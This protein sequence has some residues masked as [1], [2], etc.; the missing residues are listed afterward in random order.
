MLFICT[1]CLCWVEL[2]IS[3]CIIMVLDG[4]IKSQAVSLSLCRNLLNHRRL[5]SSFSGDLEHSFPFLWFA[6]W[7]SIH[8]A[9]LARASYNFPFL[10]VLR[11]WR[12]LFNSK[13][14]IQL[15]KREWLLFL[16]YLP[17]LCKNMHFFHFW[18][19][20]KFSSS[21]LHGRAWSLCAWRK[22]VL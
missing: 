15:W 22:V 12:L 20:C 2:I 3:S 19:H 4:I 6:V 8:W 13:F 1:M 18:Y 17:T 9:T 16:S 11:S 14:H 7:R 21:I 5:N 10:N